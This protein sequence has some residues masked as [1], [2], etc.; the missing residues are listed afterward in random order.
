MNYIFLYKIQKS[1]FSYN[2]LFSMLK[3]IFAAAIGRVSCGN[4]QDAPNFLEFANDM[5]DHF[6]RG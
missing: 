1:I 4:T 2:Y 6:K 5:E 3:Y